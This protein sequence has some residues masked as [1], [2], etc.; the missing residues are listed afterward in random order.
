MGLGEKLAIEGG[1][2]PNRKAIGWAIGKASSSSTFASRKAIL[3][4]PQHLNFHMYMG[5]IG[6]KSF[7]L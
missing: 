3:L 4:L 2:F 5:V 6:I 7:I 1:E